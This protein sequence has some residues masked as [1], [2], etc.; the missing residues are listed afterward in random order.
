MEL[1]FPEDRFRKLF[2]TDDDAIA[3]MERWWKR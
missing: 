3:D 1:K 2:L